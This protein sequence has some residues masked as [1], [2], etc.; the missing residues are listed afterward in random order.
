MNEHVLIN[1]LDNKFNLLNNKNVKPLDVVRSVKKWSSNHGLSDIYT[2]A[3]Q[4][5][6][7]PVKTANDVRFL[8]D[9]LE[10]L[11]CLSVVIPFDIL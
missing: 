4:E 11:I 9:N 3:V 2:Q 5:V 6:A 10:E 8:I 1:E 7:H